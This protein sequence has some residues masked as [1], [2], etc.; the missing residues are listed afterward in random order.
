MISGIC[1]FANA[2]PSLPLQASSSLIYEVLEKYDPDNLLLDQS[3][4]EVLQ[5]QLEQNRLY[6]ALQ[7]IQAGKIIVQPVRHP[8][9]F[10]FPLL[11]SRLRQTVSSETL[12]DRIRKMQLRYEK[13][14]G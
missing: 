14:A 3:Q 10:A 12:E 1:C 6:K 13:W 2:S 4:Q 5:R 7:R 9:P 8:T 11:V